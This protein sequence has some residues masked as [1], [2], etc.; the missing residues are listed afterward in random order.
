MVE[1]RDRRSSRTKRRPARATAAGRRSGRTG[2]GRKATPKGRERAS[3]ST[4]PGTRAATPKS[5]PTRRLGTTGR[6]SA[7]PARAAKSRKTTKVKAAPA[8]GPLPETPA[9]PPVGQASAAAAA[10]A[11]VAEG[12]AARPVRTRR[13]RGPRIKFT[14]WL[15]SEELYRQLG[16]SPRGQALVCRELR[17]EHD[18]SWSARVAAVP[19]G[20]FEATWVTVPP[21]VLV[22]VARPKLV[23]ARR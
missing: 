18:G 1:R 8:A 2:A 16:V 9:T 19:T 3:R 11:L 6:K 23:D 5:V 4:K 7:P 17:A 15:Y 22:P 20:F 10:A 13:R 14:R 21:E 12:S